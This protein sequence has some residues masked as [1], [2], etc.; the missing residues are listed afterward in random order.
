MPQK[1]EEEP[2][3]LTQKSTTTGNWFPDVKYCVLE[4]RCVTGDFAGC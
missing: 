2:T 3:R 1:V 4:E